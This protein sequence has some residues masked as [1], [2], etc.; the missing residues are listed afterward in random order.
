MLALTAQSSLAFAGTPIVSAT[1]AHAART[2]STRTCMAAVALNATATPRPY[3]RAPIK[4]R[5]THITTS[6]HTLPPSPSSTAHAPVL[7]GHEGE[8]AQE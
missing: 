8:G 1:H 4:R 5:N 6:H 2:L 7:A 3:T